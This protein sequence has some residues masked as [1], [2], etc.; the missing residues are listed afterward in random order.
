MVNKMI[1]QGRMVADPELKQTNSGVPVCSFRVA[2]SEKYKETETKL[3]LPCT[4]WRGTAELISKHF[5]KGKEIIVEGRLSTRH[6]QDKDG[7]P[8]SSNDLTVS[9]VH[10]AGS[11][12]DAGPAPDQEPAA[13]TDLDGDDGDLPF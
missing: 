7:N 2:W 1:L 12:S 8:R 5:H 10:F 9:S 6:W 11:K 3:F 13:F 4:A